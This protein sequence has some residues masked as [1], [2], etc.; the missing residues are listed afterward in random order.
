LVE[1]SGHWSFL[2]ISQKKRWRDMRA[3]SLL[4]VVVS[5]LAS[6]AGVVKKSVSWQMY[7]N[8]WMVAGVLVLLPIIAQG[9]TNTGPVTVRGNVSEIVALSVSPNWRQESVQINVQSDL[10]ALTLTLSGS[11]PEVV[12]VRVPILIRSNIRYVISTLVRSQAVTSA[13]F[14]VL[15]ARS[16]GR[17]VAPDAVANLNVAR[18]LDSRTT[19]GTIQTA[20][21]PL[22][23][24]SPLAILRGPRVSL[25]GTLNSTDNALEVT[26]LITVKPDAAAGNWLLGLTLS[27]SAGDRY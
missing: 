6:I 2:E 5:G 22:N 4:D 24:S 26:L 17:F 16:T 21:L 1:S 13:N 12:A 3:T 23:L 14:A 25:A 15:D 20:S 7:R 27:G 19:N 10:K 11:G 8:Y 9:Q 18:E